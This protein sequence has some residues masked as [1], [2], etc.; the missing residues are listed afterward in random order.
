MIVLLVANDVYHLVDGE[1][2]EAHFGCSDVLSHV[3]AGAVR[4]QQQLLVESFAC[5]VGPNRVVVLAEEE[6]LGKSFLHLLL[7]DEIGVRLV[8]YLVKAYAEGLVGLV[9]SG[10]Y[11][12][13]HLL[14]QC[15]NLRIVLL[16]LNKHLVSLLDERRFFL[17]LLLGSFLVHAFS[18]VLSLQSLHFL[19]IVLVEGYVVVAD[20]VVALLA[21]SLRCLAVAVLQPCEHRLADVY[22]TVVYDVGLHHLVAVSLHNLC[23]RP[24]E[25]V[26]ANVSEVER[27][28]GVG[29]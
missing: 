11:P 23:Q 17:S 1:V 26:V 16:P 15:A 3:Y 24:S 10:I 22:T 7:T 18:H 25:Q 2:V 29:R 9:E 19:A 20:K 21:R 14:P 6:S 28:V 27:L 12:V 8:V 13:V 5:E 4:A